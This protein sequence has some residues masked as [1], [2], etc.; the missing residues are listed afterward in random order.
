MLR[1]RF[2]IG[3][4]L[5]GA[6]VAST[7]YADK[8]KAKALYAEG[9]NAYD[10]GKF[11]EASALF[12]K[13]YAE[14]PDPVF[15]YNLGQCHRQLGKNDRALFFYRGY[16]RNKPDAQNRAQVEKLIDDLEKARQTQTQTPI[17]PIPPGGT[18][19]PEPVT[20]PPAP[21]VTPP[22]APRPTPTPAPVA[23]TGG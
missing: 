11:E 19:Q 6:L 13:G 2:L 10:L 8:A 17:A 4:A 20:P 14:Q 18:P 15:L 21:Q 7:A 1:A 9:Q 22:P 16:L 23:A 3:A 12:E 5:A